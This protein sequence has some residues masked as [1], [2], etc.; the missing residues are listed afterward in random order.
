MALNSLFCADVPLSNYSL[1]HSPTP[2]GRQQ[3]QQQRRWRRGRQAPLQRQFRGR[4]NRQ[5]QPPQ[6]FRTTAAKCASW[7]HVLASHWCSADIEHV[8]SIYKTIQWW[9]ENF[10]NW[11][12][13]QSHTQSLFYS[14]L[15]RWPKSRPLSLPHVAISKTERTRNKHKTDEQLT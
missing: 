7:R 1:T 4:R 2:A 5:R 13:N 10:R 11:S 9:H 12:I 3:Q 8:D 15:K 14:A 6:Q